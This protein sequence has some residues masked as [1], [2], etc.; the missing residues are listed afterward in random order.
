V[1]AR[2]QRVL[3]PLGLVLGQEELLGLAQAPELQQLLVQEFPLP[4][5]PLLRPV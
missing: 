5:A 3:Q 4:Q 1:P 2:E